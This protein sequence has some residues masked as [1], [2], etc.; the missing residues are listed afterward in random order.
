MSTTE[1]LPA[2]LVNLEIEAV[3]AR[4]RQGSAEQALAAAAQLIQQLSSS[5]GSAPAPSTGVIDTRT[6]GNSRSRRLRVRRTQ[7]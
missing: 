4:Q 3:Q 1:E 5:R 6:L 2:T 7:E